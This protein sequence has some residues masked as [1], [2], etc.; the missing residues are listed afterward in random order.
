[1]DTAATYSGESSTVSSQQP[2][3]PGLPLGDRDSA[4]GWTSLCHLNSGGHEG[5]PAAAVAM[6]YGRVMMQ[7][8]EENRET[9][10]AQRVQKKAQK[11]PGAPFPVTP[12]RQGPG[13]VAA[14]AR[15]T[16]FYHYR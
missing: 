14:A 4:S 6:P 13:T 7:R 11:L 3:P 2:Q 15:A 9:K 8:G 12:V 5:G 16:A 10:R 1:M